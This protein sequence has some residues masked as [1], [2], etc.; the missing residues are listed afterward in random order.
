MIARRR[1]AAPKND[2]RLV[3]KHN[4]SASTAPRFLLARGR[5]VAYDVV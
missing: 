1:F 2:N 4:F 3:V 5:R